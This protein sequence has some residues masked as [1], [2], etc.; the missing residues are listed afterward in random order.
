MLMSAKWKR[1]MEERGFS[2][3]LYFVALFAVAGLF[4]LSAPSDACA[5]GVHFGFGVDVPIGGYGPPPVVEYVPPVVVERPAPP[6]PVV[7]RRTP[8]AVIYEGPVVVERRSTVYYYSPPRQ[9]PPYYQESRREYYRERTYHSGVD[10]S[11]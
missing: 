4:V 8:P 7:V 3:P 5:G 11:Y 6:P 9:P 1:L 10:E 2:M